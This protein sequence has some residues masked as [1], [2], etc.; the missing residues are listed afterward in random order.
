MPE[1]MYWLENS[2]Q[3]VDSFQS[4]TWPGGP[5]KDFFYICKLMR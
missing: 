5:V 4:E 2:H 3:T 1:A